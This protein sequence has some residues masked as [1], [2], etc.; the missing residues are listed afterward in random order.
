MKKILVTGANGQL[1]QAFYEIA[2]AYHDLHFIW[3][4]KE[5]LD[6]TSEKDIETFFNLD[7]F[8]GVI[9]CAAYTAVDKAEAE[10]ELAYLVNAKATKYL[11]EKTAQLRIPFVHIST[12]YV[13]D[14]KNFKPYCEEYQT[15]CA[16]FYQHGSYV[17]SWKYPWR[18][19]REEGGNYQ[20]WLP[21]CDHKAEAGSGTGDCRY[22]QQA[23]CTLCGI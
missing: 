3:V 13:F 14:G 19:R 12:D 1:G 11:A 20:T 7:S 9:N 23:S 10:P 22:L 6:I 16:G 18:N 17:I 15:G 21:G 4:S 5:E 2:P 8:H